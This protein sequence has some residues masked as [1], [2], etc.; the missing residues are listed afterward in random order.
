MSHDDPFGMPLDPPRPELTVE[1]H[2][3]VDRLGGQD[4]GVPGLGDGDGFHQNCSASVEP[5]RA[6]V[7][8]SGFSAVETASK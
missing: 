1:R 4:V 2:D 6:V 3:E 5:D 8:L 7:E